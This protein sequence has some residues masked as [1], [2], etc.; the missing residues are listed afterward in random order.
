MRSLLRLAAFIAVVGI[1]F[2]CTRKKS[3]LGEKYFQEG[4]YQLAI[5]EYTKILDIRPRSLGVLYNRGRSF[6]ELGEENKAILDFEKVLKL[7]NDH[8][9]A[10][11]SLGNIDFQ[12]EDYEGAYYQ[13]NLIVKK[14][15][16]N[17]DG[18][19][20]R[21]KANF[22]L[23][24]IRGALQDYNASIRVNSQNGN[25]YLYRGALNI[26]RKRLRSACADFRKANTLGVDEAS[27]A[28][29]KYCD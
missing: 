17:S 20:F 16:Q 23:G 10:H 8:V 27:E 29:D 12:N 7:D 1:F 18:L 22:K 28:I 14:F 13:F 19:M 21:G 5:D 3:D 15:S 25:A 11:L 24:N 9:Q 6:Q 4:H 26:N 2:G